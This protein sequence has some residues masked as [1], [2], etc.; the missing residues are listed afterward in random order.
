M[1]DQSCAL[2][3]SKSDNV[4]TKSLVWS[5]TPIRRQRLGFLDEFNHWQKFEDMALDESES[6]LAI[7][8]FQSLGLLPTERTR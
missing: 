7:R 2:T 1:I 4:I 5:P 8:K 3:R 6:P